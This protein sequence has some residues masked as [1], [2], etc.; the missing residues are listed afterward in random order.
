MNDDGQPCNPANSTNVA[1]SVLDLSPTF[2]QEEYSGQ[3]DEDEGV[4]FVVVEVSIMIII[5]IFIFF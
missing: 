3:V 1:I 2:S 4:G 5:F